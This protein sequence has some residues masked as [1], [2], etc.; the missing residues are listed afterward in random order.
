MKAPSLFDCPQAASFPY[1]E[2]VMRS[3]H[4]IN[5]E[6]PFFCLH[7]AV[8]LKR[9]CPCLCVKVAITLPY[10]SL[11]RLPF[12]SILL[13]EVNEGRMRVEVT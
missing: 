5:K 3:G 13:T 10:L 4:E 12:R 9:A 7:H 6:S 1:W 11:V 2:R 8:C